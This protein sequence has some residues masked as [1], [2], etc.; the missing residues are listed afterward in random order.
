MRTLT[1]SSLTAAP[2]LFTIGH[3][4]RPIEE[5]GRVLIESGV[6]RLL[7]VRR[8][9]G[10]R[11]HPH[12]AREALERSLPQAGVTYE[13][14]GDLLGGRR[15]SKRTESR[16]LA[17]RNAG[18]QGYADYMDSP[19]FETALERLKEDAVAVPRAA[20]MCAET[21][22]WKC[23]RRLIA[24]ALTLHRVEVTHLIAPGSSQPHKLH[25]AAR[26]DEEGK[27]VYDV[28]VERELPLSDDA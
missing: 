14:R 4:T 17:W 1:E 28:G 25:P 2:R 26:L 7:D 24:D 18:F 9:P 13:W 11:R 12:F 5:L 19:E 21:L 6:G 27:V 22:W 16:H 20:I 8:Y 3:G 10:S 23:H 15:S